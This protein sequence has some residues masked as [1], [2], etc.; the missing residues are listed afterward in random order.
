MARPGWIS[1]V[2]SPEL[3]ADWLAGQQCRAT[4]GADGRW[5][6]RLAPAPANATP[7]TLTI[8]GT[9]TH[10][11][12]D[13]LIGEV[14]MCSG[15]SNMGFTLA[16]D[17]N[18]DLEVAAAKLPDS[19]LLK[20]PLLGTQEL[21]GDFKGQ[22]QASTPESARGFSAVGFLFGR[23]IQRIVG[24]PVG[25]IDN[26]WGGQPDLQSLLQ[27]GPARHALPHGRFRADHEA[28]SRAALKARS[29]DSQG[30]PLPV[31]AVWRWPLAWGAPT[32]QCALASGRWGWGPR[33]KP[34]WK[35]ALRR[36]RTRAG[37]RRW[38]ANKMVSLRSQWV[39][40]AAKRLPGRGVRP[41]CPFRPG[42]PPRPPEPMPQRMKP[43]RTHATHAGHAGRRPSRAFTL[44]ELLVVI[45]IIAI[46]AGLLLPALAQAKDKA[47]RISCLSNLRQMGLGCQMYADDNR[48]YLE[49]NSRGLAYR[50]TTEDDVS[51]LHPTYIPGP[52]CFICPATRNSIRTNSQF[53]ASAGRDLLVDLFVTALGGRDGTNG[54]SYEVLSEIGN[55]TA[56]RLTQNLVLTYTLQTF[57]PL[58]GTRPGPSAFWVFFDSDNAGTNVE[59]DKLDNHRE[60]GGN[61]A[62][63]DGHAAWLPNKKHHFEWNRT[64]DLNKFSQY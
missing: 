44:I 61:V 4:A 31:S 41:Q 24:V 60:G 28:Q 1:T 17:W 12:G 5:T 58:I 9:T 14:W 52:N 19:R 27:R 37:R 49:A 29:G 35:S 64:R 25:L 43:T 40:M 47:K 6:V 55:N 26:A 18:G 42:P 63:C 7:Q 32:V 36:P 39:N 22:W 30:P 45:A 46:L 51:W 53:D 21:Q 3:R 62:Y 38:G 50:T 20:V 23:Y 59:W 33:P 34:A 11:I 48:G 13:V 10:V 15:Q 16:Q 8:A 57:T 54:T 2:L 56:N